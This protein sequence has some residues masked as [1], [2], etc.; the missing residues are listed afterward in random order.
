M[1]VAIVHNLPIPRTQHVFFVG[2]FCSFIYP[3]W[4]TPGAVAVVQFLG[5]YSGPYAGFLEFVR[6]G[7]NLGFTGNYRKLWDVLTEGS[8]PKAALCH[9]SPSHIYD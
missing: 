6:G 5:P 9:V 2:V 7:R 4:G 8:N 3:F 1:F